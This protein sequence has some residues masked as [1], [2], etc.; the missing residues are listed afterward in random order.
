MTDTINVGDEITLTANKD[1][2]HWV[3]GKRKKND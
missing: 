1:K 3:I 2:T